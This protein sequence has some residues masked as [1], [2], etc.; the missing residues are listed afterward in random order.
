MNDKC[1][2]NIL[3]KILNIEWRMNEEFEVCMKYQ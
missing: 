1:I 2:K 3:K